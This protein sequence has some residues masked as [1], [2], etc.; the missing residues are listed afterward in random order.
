MS[1]PPADW[2]PDPTGRH[3]LRYW[4][5]ES[6]TEHVADGGEQG[7]DPLAD[8]GDSGSEH[9]GSAAGASSTTTTRSDL[10]GDDAEMDAQAPGPGDDAPEESPTEEAG[11][12]GTGVEPSAAEAGSLQRDGARPAAATPHQPPEG[13]DAAVAVLEDPTLVP[14]ESTLGTARYARAVVARDR[15]RRLVHRADA[16]HD[17]DPTDLRAR[18]AQAREAVQGDVDRR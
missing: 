12:S 14:I 13:L 17:V 1:L 5:G 9:V 7:R 6:W 18:A 4:D 10:Q 3:E 15:L 8:A 16:G 2:H 11:A